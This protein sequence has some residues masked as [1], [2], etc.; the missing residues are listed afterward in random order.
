VD[1]ALATPRQ[2]VIAGA[3]DA[4]DTQAMLRAVRERFLPHMVLLLADGGARQ[5][6]L[7]GR[8]KFLASFK[9]LDGKATAYVCANHACQAPTTELE[10][11]KQVLTAR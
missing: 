3:P 1:S 9:P 11:L 5:A 6:A 2:I 10:K 8:L 7:A 4:G